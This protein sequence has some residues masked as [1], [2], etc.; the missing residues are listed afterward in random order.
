M[1]TR[2]WM[3]WVLDDSAKQT[4]PLPWAR[5]TRKARAA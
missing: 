4:A 3:K 2:R 1:K 5:A